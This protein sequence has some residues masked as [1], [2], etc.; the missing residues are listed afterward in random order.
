[1]KAE[2]YST[3]FVH[4]VFSQLI[5][6]LFSE[7]KRAFAKLGASSGND[8]AKKNKLKGHFECSAHDLRT[9]NFLHEVSIPCVI[10]SENQ[11]NYTGL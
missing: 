9:L 3:W 5:I 7:L 8:F 11:S 4:A 6:D 2:S 10:G 1:M